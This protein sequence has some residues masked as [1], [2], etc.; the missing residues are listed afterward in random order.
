MTKKWVKVAELLNVPTD[1]VDS[2]LASHLNDD[3]ASLQKV[4]E[5]WFRNTAKPEWVTINN[6]LESKLWQ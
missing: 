2:I 4:V 5:W 1:I 3:A 6:I